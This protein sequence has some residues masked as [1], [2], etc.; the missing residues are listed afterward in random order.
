MG[1]F[2]RELCCSSCSSLLSAV[3]SLCRESNTT[4]K[5]NFIDHKSQQCEV[6]TQNMLNK[7]LTFSLHYVKEQYRSLC[8]ASDS[9]TQNASTVS[10]V[11]RFC[12]FNHV[13]LKHLDTFLGAVYHRWLVLPQQPE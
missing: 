12:S 9:S 7:S 11:G 6:V 3:I 8:Q 4:D 13:V 5:S 1:S 10:E 2:S